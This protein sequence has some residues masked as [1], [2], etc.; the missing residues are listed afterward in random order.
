[1]HGKV[2]LDVNLQDGQFDAPDN[3]EGGYEF[4][5]ARGIIVMDTKD[6]PFGDMGIVAIIPIG[7]AQVSSVNMTATVGS[8]LLKGEEFGYFLFGGSDIILLFQKGKA[9]KIDTCDHYR[10]YGTSVSTCP[11]E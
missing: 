1:V 8:H 10:H 5:Q 4:A 11:P 7:M 6:S 9:P 3:T 2:K